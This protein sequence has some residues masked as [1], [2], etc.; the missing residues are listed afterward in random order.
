MGDNTITAI[1]TPP[2]VG[3]IGVVRIS[4]PEAKDILKR[5]WTSSHISV[6]KCVTHRMYYGNIVDN[7]IENVGKPQVIDNVL[8]VFMEAPNSYTGENLVEI[9]C[10]AGAYLTERILNLIINA[11]ARPAEPGEFTKRAYLNNRMDLLQ[12]E[13]V[14][15]VIGA[16]S[17]RSLK[18]A[19]EQ[20]SGR[21]SDEIAK[22]KTALKEIKA[23]VEATI[24]FPEEDIEMINQCGIKEKIESIRFETDK[25]SSTYSEGR[26]LRE[27]V[28][29]VIVGKPNVGKSSLM[30]LLL[31]SERVIVHDT[32]GTTRDV[33]EEHALIGGISFMLIDTAGIHDSVCEIEKMGIIKTR[34]KLSEADLTIVVLDAASGVDKKDEDVLSETKNIPRIVIVNKSDKGLNVADLKF[35]L[36]TSAATGDG[37]D[38]LKEMMTGFVTKKHKSEAGDSIITRQRHKNSLEKISVS[39]ELA[40][41]SIENKESAE[42]VACHLQNAMDSLGELTGEITSDDVLNEIFSKFCI[43]K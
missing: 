14:A 6:D 21:L 37:I 27:G 7:I 16:S 30:N 23:S 40:T 9:H 43:G 32:P 10:H 36:K 22:I 8:A 19:Q 42:F 34:L 38:N 39:L 29:V 13:A 41:K 24:D 28:K 17:E 25:L 15:D 31:G 3:A 20:L 12:C 1:S 33:I 11:G 35:D 26:L 4:G 2:G 5:V 18:L